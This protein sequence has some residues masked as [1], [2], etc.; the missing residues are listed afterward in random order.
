MEKIKR[1]K[2]LFK[3]EKID[4]YVVPKND[5]FFGEYVPD[6]ND[7]LNYISNFSGSYGIALILKNESYLFVDGRYTLQAN[8]QSGNF[9]KVI[10]FPQKMPSDILKN[11]KLTIGL[12]PKLF[13]KRT[14][15]IF[16][17]KNKCKFKFL[18]NNLVD[19]IWQKKIKRN[20]NKFYILPEGVVGYNYKSKIDKVVA[21]LKK[22]RSDYL[23]ITASENNA[24]LLNIRGR[25]TKY[26]PIPYSYVLIDKNRNIKLFCDLKKI[27]SP[28]KKQFKKIDVIDKNLIER[29]LSRII[30]KKFIIDKNS[31]SIFFENMISKNNKILNADDP[32]YLLKAIKNYKE[33]KNIKKAHIDDGVA[34][35]KYLFWL[36]EN[37]RKKKVTEISASKKLFSLRKK[38]KKFKFSSFPTISGT[39]PNGAIIHYKATK[40]TNRKLK[41]GDIYLVDSGGQY[42][43]GTTDVTRTISL[44]NS[45]RRIK[46]IF[47]RVLKG[48][49]AVSNFKLKENTSGEIVDR[50]ARKHLK[51]IGLDYAHG[52]GHGVGYFLNVHEGPHAISK[53][54]KIKFQEGMIVSNEPGYYEKN[55]FGIRIENLVYVKKEKNKKYFENLTMAPIDKDLI[56]KKFL[57]KK[58]KSWLNLYHKKVYYNLK[59][60]MNK[61]ELIKLKTACSAI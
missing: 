39:G 18:E 35:T 26:T 51:E 42:N 49:I 47:T 3:R 31:C 19:E 41:K 45:N 14:L 2:N 46:N 17:G 24:W 60:A 55:K 20:K 27:S 13:T 43:F 34:L 12:D 54:N 50:Y 1:L 57:N 38:N 59:N 8:K 6:H 61:K 7:R 56:D 58:E 10:T 9:F 4:G 33:I 53:N 15:K 23:F 32:I 21:F 28:F 44:Q 16:F 48:H 37:F 30:N 29:I 36:K 25:D 5:D 52:T 11:K 40:K 22:R